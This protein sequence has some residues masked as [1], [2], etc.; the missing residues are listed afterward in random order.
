MP[1]FTLAQRLTGTLPASRPGLFN[2]W[3]DWCDADD[4][5]NPLGGPEG[6]MSRLAEHLDCDP[7]YIIC[8]QSPGWRGC[9]YSGIAFTSE[10]QVIDGAIPRISSSPDRLT[11][12]SPQ[13]G[14]L[15]EPSSTIMWNT[16]RRLGISGDVLLWN[17]LQMHPHQPSLPWSNRTPTWGEIQLG[18]AALEML[19]DAFPDAKVIA[20]GRKSEDLLR[21]LDML[22]NGQL[23]HPAYGGAR[24]FAEGM[25]RLV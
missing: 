13:G 21:E 22:P 8:G 14:P 25:R 18:A 17:A 12:A 7:R 6:R 10:R 16:L 23:R 15:S 24:Q 9:R 3:R 20:I 4:R 5:S 19:L 2:P 11:R 1:N